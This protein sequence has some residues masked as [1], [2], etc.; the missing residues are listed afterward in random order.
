[1]IVI[2]LSY[3]KLMPLLAGVAVVESFVER[4]TIIMNVANAEMTIHP[5]IIIK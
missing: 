3:V 1:M 5:D 4:C 2:F